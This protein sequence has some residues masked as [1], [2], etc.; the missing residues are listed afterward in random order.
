[1]SFS[2][3]QRSPAANTLARPVSSAPSTRTRVQLGLGRERADDPGAG[4][5]V[6]VQ[7]LVRTFDELEAVTVDV[8]GVELDR[9]RAGDLADH[10]VPVLDAR[11]DD[12]HLHAHAEP[13][14]NAHSRVMA[15]SVAQTDARRPTALDRRPPPRRVSSPARLSARVRRELLEDRERR[16][17]LDR[18]ELERSP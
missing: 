13:S 17:A 14:P 5:A 6:A 2:I 8:I 3:A 7:V 10:R 1:M 4:G 18:P 11:V 9:D 16:A 15:P 12:R